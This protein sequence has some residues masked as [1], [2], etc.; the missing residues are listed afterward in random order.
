[1]LRLEKVSK[2]FSNGF[3]ALD[4]INL[5]VNK[6]EIISLVGTSGC[7]K[8]TLLRII[9]GLEYP[10]L[11]H[12]FIDDEPIKKPHPKIGIIFQEPRLMPWLTVEKM[13]NLD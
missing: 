3:L 9:A 11:G 7:G 5:E 1:M 4:N 8:S 13:Y 6:G 12:V 2:R 10:T